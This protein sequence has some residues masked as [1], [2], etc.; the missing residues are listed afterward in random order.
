M[1]KSSKL[2]SLTRSFRA[3]CHKC[4]FYGPKHPTKPPATRDALDHEARNESH[5]AY[6]EETYERVTHHSVS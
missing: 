4:R 1:A 5:V 6:V 2:D 3:R